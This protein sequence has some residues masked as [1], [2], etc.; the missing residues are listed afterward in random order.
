[1]QEEQEKQREAELSYKAWEESK[2]EKLAKEKARQRREEEKKKQKEL[3]DIE[4]KRAEAE[5]VRALL[6]WS[7]T[8]G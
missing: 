7:Q 8:T 4:E 3:Q 6:T 2:K 5:V 1:M